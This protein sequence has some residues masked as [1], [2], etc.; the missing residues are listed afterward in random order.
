MSIPP[1]IQEGSVPPLS[2]QATFFLTGSL[3]AA[4]AI[5]IEPLFKILVQRV[6][7]PI[8]PHVWTPI[9]SSGI[10]FWIFDLARSQVE[11]LPIPTAF[12][13]GLSGAAGGLA[14]ICVQSLVKYQRPDVTSMMSQSMKLFCC[15]GTYTFLSTR[16]SPDELPPKPFWRCWLMGATA[17][18]LGS[19]ILA[20]IQGVKGSALWKGAVPKGALT[21]GT[22][23]SVQVTT[24]AEL[25]Q[26]NPFVAD[27]KP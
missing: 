16:L 26:N 17:G 2:N 24:C 10:R 8:W 18:G 22:V 14:E 5:P 25:L 7:P 20:R 19:G 11:P 9:Y 15:F 1:S 21:I 27:E 6:P 4:A 12:K 13:G 3:A 23:I